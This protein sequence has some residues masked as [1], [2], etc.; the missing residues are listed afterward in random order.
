MVIDVV[1]AGD[2]HIRAV[3]AKLNADDLEVPP[4][5]ARRGEKETQV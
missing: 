3:A 4:R 1:A 5:L 2:A